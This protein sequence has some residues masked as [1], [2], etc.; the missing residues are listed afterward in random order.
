[1]DK[2]TGD[3]LETYGHQVFSRMQILCF[4]KLNHVRLEQLDPTGPYTSDEHLEFD[5]LIPYGDVC[6]VG[7]IT[8][9]TIPSDVKDK[10]GRF[11]KHYNIVNNLTLNE[12][13][14]LKLGV[15]EESLHQFRSVTQLRGFFLTT[16]LQEFDL[17]LGAVPNIIVFYK[18]NCR[19]LEEYSRSIGSYAKSHFLHRFDIAET[20]ARHSLRLKRDPHGLIMTP[21]K[22]IASGDIGA[23]DLYTFEASPYELL[24]L[25][26][27][28]RRPFAQF[29]IFDRI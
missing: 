14:W 20:A 5:Y 7:E 16:K 29:R 6:L 23:A 25:A 12:D 10:Y 3:E 17:N 13:I 8:A 18:S 4:H 24:P 28:Y 27:V 11:R 2:L 19:L 21:D 1:M 15:P 26:E 9:R 22:K